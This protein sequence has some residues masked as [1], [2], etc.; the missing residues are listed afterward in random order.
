MEQSHSPFPENVPM[1]HSNFLHRHDFRRRLSESDLLDFIEGDWQKLK[2]ASKSAVEEMAEYMGQRSPLEQIFIKLL[3]YQPG[4]YVKAGSWVWVN[5]QA[6][7]PPEIRYYRALSVITE[8]AG[9]PLGEPQYWF[10]AASD[11]RSTVVRDFAVDIA[12]Y[13]LTPANSPVEIMN[14]FRQFYDD[15][16]AWCKVY[17]KSDRP[18]QLP[19]KSPESRGVMIKGGKKRKSGRGSSH[20]GNGNGSNRYDGW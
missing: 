5:V 1:M 18:T 2:E 16:I 4:Q 11:P 7:Q 3:E 6:D 17:M 20:K 19:Q 10:S 9:I 8:D 15:A 13:R 12:L 14:Q